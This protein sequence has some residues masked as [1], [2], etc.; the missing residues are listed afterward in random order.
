MQNYPTNRLLVDCELSY[1]AKCLPIVLRATG[2]GRALCGDCG[3]VSRLS[4]VRQLLPYARAREHS[5]DALRR[6][7]KSVPIECK[8]SANSVDS[9]QCKAVE[10]SRERTGCPC[11]HCQ[12]SELILMVDGDKR[13]H[14]P[15]ARPIRSPVPGL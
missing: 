13:H 14:W 1:R 7:C 8:S 15:I 11:K 10:R 6:Q 4:R 2:R 5:V 9:L 3:C 12:R